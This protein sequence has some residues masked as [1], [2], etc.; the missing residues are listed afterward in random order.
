METS[1]SLDIVV[2]GFF[3]VDIEGFLVVLERLILCVN[4]V[5]ADGVYGVFDGNL[6]G[7]I[8]VTEDVDAEVFLIVLEHLSLCVDVVG[9]Y[10]VDDVFDI[11]LEGLITLI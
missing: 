4:V 1:N 9:A 3:V 8:T 2:V 11:S 6:E 7:L 10:G 5:R